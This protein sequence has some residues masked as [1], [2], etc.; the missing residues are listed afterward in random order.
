MSSAYIAVSV[1]FDFGMSLMYITKRKGPSMETCE[2][3]ARMLL[4]VDDVPFTVR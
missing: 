3:P 1:I 2:T 4:T